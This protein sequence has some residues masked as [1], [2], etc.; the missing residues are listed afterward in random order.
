MLKDINYDGSE[1]KFSARNIETGEREEMPKSQRDLM[2]KSG[3]YDEAKDER[4]PSKYNEIIKNIALNLY[5]IGRRRQ[6]HG[7]LH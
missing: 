2:V 5:P 3:A 4:T 6:C 7:C 1:E